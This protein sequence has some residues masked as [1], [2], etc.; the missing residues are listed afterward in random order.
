MQNGFLE[1]H[2]CL[3]CEVRRQNGGESDLILGGDGFLV[4]LVEKPVGAL[5]GGFWISVGG[6]ERGQSVVDRLYCE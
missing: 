3:V 1:V 5:D 4:K 6:T 2:L